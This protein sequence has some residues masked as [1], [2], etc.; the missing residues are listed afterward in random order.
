MKQL[1]QLLALLFLLFH[2]NSKAQT[3]IQQDWRVDPMLKQVDAKRPGLTIFSR[4]GNG[5]KYVN[6]A[7]LSDSTRMLTWFTCYGDAFEA[8]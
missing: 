4:K 3:D 6:M 5:Q 8:Y 2:V 7:V 1:S